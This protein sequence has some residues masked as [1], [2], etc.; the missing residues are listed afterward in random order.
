MSLEPIHEDTH[1]LASGVYDFIENVNPTQL[2][3]YVAIA[4]GV[5]FI[6]QSLRITLTHLTAL[7]IA[8]L[9]M[10][11]L[12]K[13]FKREHKIKMDDIFLKLHMIRPRPKWFYMDSDIIELVDDVKEYREYNIVA[14][15]RV[16]YA[17]DNFLEIIHDMELGVRD[18]K[19]NIDIA[20]HQKRIAIDNLQSILFKLPVDRA[21]EYKLEQAI[22]NLRFMLQR[23]IDKMIHTLQK[24]NKE[25]GYHKDSG[26][27]YF[28]HPDGI[29]PEPY[30]EYLNHS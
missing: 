9:I 1:E 5:L 28:D 13:K 18:Y 25:E 12:D 16:I 27:Y 7:L 19:D 3:Q 26:I 20:N 14:W 24:I 11:Y 15:S 10:F 2:F 4:V 8:S 23:H 30:R 17:L 22:H 6:F 21:L 29:D